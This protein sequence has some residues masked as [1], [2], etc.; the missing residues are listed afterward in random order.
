MTKARKEM[1]AK[2]K[3][4][5]GKK[6]VELS[7]PE[8]DFTYGKPTKPPTPIKDVIGHTY[9]ETAAAQTMQKYE[10]ISKSVR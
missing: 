7:I 6:G 8:P 5:K 2:L 9:G 4:N 10:E 1:D 3:P